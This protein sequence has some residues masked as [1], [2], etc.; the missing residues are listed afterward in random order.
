MWNLL[1]DLPTKNPTNNYDLFTD[2]NVEDA[3]ETCLFFLP[4]EDRGKIGRIYCN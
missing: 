4:S 3:L 1:V 2:K